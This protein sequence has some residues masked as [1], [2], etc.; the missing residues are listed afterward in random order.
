[1]K[2]EKI[3]DGVKEVIWKHSKINISYKKGVPFLTRY[4]DFE[5]R[6]VDVS[7]KEEEIGDV[8]DY[9]YYIEITTFSYL[10]MCAVLFSR[11]Y[12]TEEEALEE[13][14]RFKKGD[15]YLPDI[16]IKRVKGPYKLPTKPK[17]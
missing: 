13:K 1:M 5:A 11:Y 12:K 3:Q 17:L 8:D 16:E 7:L 10:E 6:F 9:P 2:D 14:E 4:D 15:E